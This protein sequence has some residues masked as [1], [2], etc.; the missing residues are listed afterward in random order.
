LEQV[1]TPC[2]R[3]LRFFGLRRNEPAGPVAQLLFSR[4]DDNKSD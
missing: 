1:W 2:S 4:Q 3:I